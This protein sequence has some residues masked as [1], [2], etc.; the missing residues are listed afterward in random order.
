MKHT[1]HHF[2]LSCI[3]FILSIKWTDILRSDSI[4]WPFP[5]WNIS[6]W[7]CR[8]LLSISKYKV[9]LLESELL[10]Y[11]LVSNLEVKECI[12]ETKIRD[13]VRMRTWSWRIIGLGWWVV[14]IKERRGEE[15]TW[16]SK[17]ID[18]EEVVLVEISAIFFAR[19]RNGLGQEIREGKTVPKN[20]IRVRDE[21]WM[22]S[23]PERYV[24]TKKKTKEW[25]KKNKKKKY[26]WSGQKHRDFFIRHRSTRKNALFND[27]FFRVLRC[28]IK[29]YAVPVVRIK[30]ILNNLKDYEWLIIYNI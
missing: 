22:R 11:W 28:R 21:K 10:E 12:W 24:L 13:K 1:H 2:C 8:Y 4:N 29:K 5:Y 16:D 15:L 20:M 25:W 6:N 23:W 17:V 14:V 27:A 30:T 7:Q 19:D 9:L 18:A 3:E 26:Y